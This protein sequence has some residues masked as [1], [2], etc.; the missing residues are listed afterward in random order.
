MIIV[1]VNLQIFPNLTV[2]P[3]MCIAP[4]LT[5]LRR[6]SMKS[7]KYSKKSTIMRIFLFTLFITYI[8]CSRSFVSNAETI[9]PIVIE[10]SDVINDSIANEVALLL[11]NHDVEMY[12]NKNYVPVRIIINSPGGN[13]YAT[14]GIIDTMMLVSFPIETEC[15]GMAA[16]AA[17]LILAMGN[18]GHRFAHND[19]KILIHYA[20]CENRSDHDE[21]IDKVL[22]GLNK[23][24]MTI[25]S[26][27]L[28][29]SISEIEFAI[30]NAG[31]EL[32]LTAD[33]AKE[34]GLVDEIIN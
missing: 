32:W 7:L 1:S 30:D 3:K 18:K 23:E 20:S 31:G 5:G 11:L 34:F 22:D 25:L 10:I 33:E 26:N 28:C 14:L 17:A 9:E 2:R 4:V 29:K 24:I 19:S 12:N 13:L 6:V 16:S 27:Q 21:S 15:N 8:L